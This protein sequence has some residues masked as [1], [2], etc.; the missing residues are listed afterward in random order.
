MR[1]RRL[2][3]AAFKDGFA[4]SNVDTHTYLFL[5]DV[6]TQSADGTAPSG[7]P[8]GPVSGQ[9][10][11][12]GMDPNV[13]APNEAALRAG[14]ASI[15]TVS[16]VTDLPNLVDPATGIYVK[17]LDHG[18]EWERPAS[19][20][21]FNDPL[22]PQPGGFQQNGGLRIRG[23]FSRSAAN[24]KHS[25][26]LFFRSEYGKGK[27]KYALFGDA[28]APEFDGFDL[29]T[30]Q[31]ASWSFLGS[32][33]NTFLRDEVARATQVLIAPGSRCRYFHVYL[34]GQYWG[35]YNTDERP[36]NNYGAQ[37]LGGL[38]EDYD[39]LKSGGLSIGYS[40]EASDGTMAAG[41]AMGETLERRAHRAHFPDRRQL[42]QAP[43]AE[44]RMASR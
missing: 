41:S 20:E 30:S 22:H 34:N 37:Y 43:R 6:I 31:D 21:I 13:V 11:D 18:A 32:P 33:E 38:K 3:A 35:L 4:P 10:F 25:F 36:N 12:Y 7:W 5:D 44:R 1:R 8:A 28:G 19:I 2:R 9:V 23:G 39:V 26:R 27:M 24:P 14:L 42:L 29:R 15:P 40:T 17:S 16:I